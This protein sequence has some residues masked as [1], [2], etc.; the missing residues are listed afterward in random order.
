MTSPT[1]SDSTGSNPWAVTRLD[2][3]LLHLQE[4]DPHVQHGRRSRVDE[5]LGPVR[6]TARSPLP[7]AQRL[8]A[9]TPN[10]QRIWFFRADAR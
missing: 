10:C 9:R 3:P 8:G 7:S 2:P 5:D 6:R 4:A 1:V